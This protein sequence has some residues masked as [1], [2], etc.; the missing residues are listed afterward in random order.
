[1]D[2][3]NLI[4]GILAGAL[5]GTAISAIAAFFANTAKER[6]IADV[7]AEYDKELEQLKAALA[8]DQKKLQAE[9]DH[10]TY[11][12]EA[13]YDLELSS[14]K[15]MW[16]AMS[17][18]RERW[19]ALFGLVDNSS[20]FKAQFG[21]RAFTARVKKVDKDLSDAYD[22]AILVSERLAPFYEKSILEEARETTLCS[23]QFAMRLKQ[24]TAPLSVDEMRSALNEIVLRVEH[25][26]GLIRDRLSSLRLLK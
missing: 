1:M 8:S 12:T 17:E 18:L 14:Y 20:E 24:G 22:N 4:G 23:Q 19:K 9:L 13:Q 26:L 6:W 7:K 16:L 25:I 21:D 2:I 10:G 5:S 11:V 15:E 3:P